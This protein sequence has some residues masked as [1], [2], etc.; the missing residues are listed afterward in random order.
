M[1]K[2]ELLN[3]LNWESPDK[4]CIDLWLW[5]QISQKTKFYYIHEK[6]TFWRLHKDSYLNTSRVNYQILDFYENLY[7]VLPPMKH[8]STKL[9]FIEKQ[10]AI[11]LKYK[12]NVLSNIKH[13]F[14]DNKFKRLSEGDN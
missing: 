5:T 1:L 6:I 8:L 12:R 11:S 2:K 10:I 13:I 3:N 4:A 7:N 14:K 9:G